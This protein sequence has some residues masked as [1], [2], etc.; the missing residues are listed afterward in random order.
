MASI[1]THAYIAEALSN[2]RLRLLIRLRL[3]GPSVGLTIRVLCVQGFG[4]TE[5]EAESVDSKKG[6]RVVTM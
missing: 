3:L 4:P 5:P 6:N 1:L 2:P